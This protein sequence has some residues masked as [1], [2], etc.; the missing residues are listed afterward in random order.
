MLGY[1][2]FRTNLPGGRAANIFTMR[3]WVVNAD[4][5][6]KREVAPG[7]ITAPN[8]WTQFAGWSP[9]GREAI[10]LSGWEGQENAA[11]EEE[12][13]E[14]RFTTGGYL[15]DCCLVN[16]N[17]GSIE[18]LTAAERVSTYNTGL[19][20]WPRQPQQLGFQAIINGES[21]PYAMRRDGTGKQDLSQQ[22][23]F[24]YGFSASPDGKRIAYHQDYRVT[25]ADADGRNAV[26]LETGQPFNFVPLWSPDGQWVSFLSGEHYHCHPYLVKSDG[27]GLRQ[28]ADRGTYPGVVKFLDVP[29]FHGGSSDVPTWSPDSRWIYYTAKIGESVELL[30]VTLDGA[31]E[32]LTVS[33]PPVQ[34]YQPTLSPD[35]RWLAFGASRDGI[36]QAYVA[37]ADGAQARPITALEPGQAAM[38]LHWQ[39]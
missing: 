22:A 5:T 6:G 39:P 28:L 36:R 8:T 34:H 20:F 24:A 15:V 4:G 13:R 26:A 17:T 32:R 14:F 7:L 16:V 2:Q 11:W 33:S 10:I 21:R 25:L 29:D 30:R 9:D 1:T 37:R 19:F 35:G 38:W 12:H 27:T 23:G 18:N 31:V 3:A